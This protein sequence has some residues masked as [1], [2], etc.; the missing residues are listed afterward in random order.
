MLL[1]IPRVY[2]INCV[3]EGGEE[4]KLAFKKEEKN[5]TSNRAKQ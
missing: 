1:N 5:D 2:S 3:K 4:I